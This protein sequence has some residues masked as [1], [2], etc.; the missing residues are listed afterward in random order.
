MA[1]HISVLEEGQLIEEGSHEGLVA[2]KGKYAEMFDI[3]AKSYR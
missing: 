2:L 3:Q 1:H